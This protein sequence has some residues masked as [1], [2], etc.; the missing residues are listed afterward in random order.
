MR[1]VD[2]RLP[3][4]LPDREELLLHEPP[5][6]GVERREGLVHEEHGGIHGESP[7]DADPLAHAPRELMRVLRLEAGETG[8]RDV[9]ARAA[10]AV[11]R[12]HAELLEAELDVR[13][14][15]APGEQGGLLKDHRRRRPARRE[16]ALELDHATARPREPGDDVEERGLAAARGADQRDELLRLDGE[17]HAPERLDGLAPAIGVRLRDPVDDDAHR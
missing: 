6:L 7:S 13:L 3:R 16:V 12:R 4:P 8:E 9:L 1:D 2:D 17:A 5:G 10:D 11:G 15:G 14:H